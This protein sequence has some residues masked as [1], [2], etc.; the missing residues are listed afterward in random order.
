MSEQ[1]REHGFILMRHGHV[2]DYTNRQ[3]DRQ[4]A[5]VKAI[6]DKWVRELLVGTPS[7]FH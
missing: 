4:L 5:E 2:D 6:G 3:D 7:L 1:A